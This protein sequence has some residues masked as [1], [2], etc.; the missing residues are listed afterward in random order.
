MRD[1]ML[2]TIMLLAQRV[3]SHPQPLTLFTPVPLSSASR[4][5]ALCSIVGA[6]A[7]GGRQQEPQG[8]GVSGSKPNHD[9]TPGKIYE[10]GLG[11]RKR[12]D[13]PIWLNIGVNRPVS[14][15]AGVCLKE[16]KSSCSL[17]VNNCRSTASDENE[18]LF[19]SFRE[20]CC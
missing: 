17:L 6:V 16:T 18:R 5:L 7:S 13:Y 20:S 9:V 4:D 2:Q 19:G 11:Y 10:T 12:L 3:L 15:V 1:F 14:R 8:E